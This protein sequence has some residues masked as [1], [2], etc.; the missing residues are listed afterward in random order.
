[1]IGCECVCGSEEGVGWGWVGGW[2]G[3]GGIGPLQD[4]ED[5]RAA[6]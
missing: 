4:A 1:M 2:V 5:V 3:G 6:G